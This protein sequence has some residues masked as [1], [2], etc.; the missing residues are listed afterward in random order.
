MKV[1]IIGSGGREHAIAWKI[2]QS[3]KLG[4]LYILPGNPG[5]A[6]LGENVGNVS[7]EDYQAILLFCLEKKIDLVIIGPEIFLAAGLA[8]VLSAAGIRVFGPSKAAAQ[9]E[10]SKV[11]SKDFMAR[12][13]IPTAEYAS[14]DR[15]PEA[16]A[17]LMEVDHPV[18]IKA[19][20]LAAGKGVIVP[21]TLDEAKSA[22]T[23]MLKN[24]QF[25]EA[26]NQVVIEERLTGQEVTLLSFCDGKTVRPMVP[27]QDHK[28][29]LEG[30]RGPNTGGMGAYAPVPACPQEM[31]SELVR[32]ALQPAVDGLRKDGYPFVGVLYGGFML[33]DKGPKVIEFNCRFGDPETQVVLP[34]LQSDFLEVALACTEGRLDSAELSWKESA[35]ACVVLASAGYPGQYSGGFPVSGLEPVKTDAI[36]FHSGTKIADGQIVT[37]GGRVL[38]VTGLGSDIPQALQAAYAQIDPIQFEGMQYRRDIGWRVIGAKR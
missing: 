14:F 1:L 29:A 21:E 20:G 31:V 33:T 34:L 18:V 4:K 26:G 38:C 2:A 9:I 37:A 15:L 25:G 11:F 30:D 8:D 23:S 22:L 5:T 13:G 16:L 12:N 27:S 24:N 32:I 10:S 28:R 7:I 3:P 19:S 6:R 17:Y 35:A 36:I